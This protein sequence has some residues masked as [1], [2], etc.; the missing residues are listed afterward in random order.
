MTMPG[1]T[2]V[3]GK[4]YRYGFNGKENDKDAGVGIQD[5]G[6]RIY[7]NRLGR[8]LS[9][10]PIT[11]SYPM[12]TPYQFASNRPIDGIDFDGL[13]YLTYTINMYV[14]SKGETTIKKTDIKWFNPNQ[15][16]AHG[17]RKGVQYIF[18]VKYQ[19][20]PNVTTVFDKFVS[21]EES[22]AG[23]PLDHGNYMGPT[24]ILQF[25]KSGEFIKDKFDYSLPAVDAIDEYSKKH[26]KAY[27]ALN[28][29]GG[30]NWRKCSVGSLVSYIKFSL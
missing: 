2:Y 10:D 8:F 17:S 22:L 1:R 4:T 23:M 18:K 29:V 12:L 20:L 9:E 11:S 19:D 26:D 3:A 28:A 15:H 6:M 13:E 24:S 14:N 21:R 25:N 5:Y 16:N 7:D 27:D 30:P